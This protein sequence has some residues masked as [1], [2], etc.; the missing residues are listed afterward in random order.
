MDVL[1]S[2]IIGCA[3]GFL[4]SKIFKDANSGLL[5]NLTSV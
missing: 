5:W 4:G 2:I 1:L 3:L